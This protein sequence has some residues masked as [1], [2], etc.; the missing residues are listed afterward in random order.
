MFDCASNVLVSTL[1]CMYNLIS[2]TLV[3][4]MLTKTANN[5]CKHNDENHNN[6]H[7]V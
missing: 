3:L 5:K 6:F 1:Y 4:I 7:G 2:S